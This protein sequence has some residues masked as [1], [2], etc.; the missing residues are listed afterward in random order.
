VRQPGYRLLAHPALRVRVAKAIAPTP[1]MKTTG[2][3][4]A[5]VRTTCRAAVPGRCPR[6]C[7][8]GPFPRRTGSATTHPAHK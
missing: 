6:L 1:T 7:A 3:I 4:R 5:S 2:H 8:K